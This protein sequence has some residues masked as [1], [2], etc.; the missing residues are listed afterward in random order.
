MVI[1]EILGVSREGDALVVAVVA[2][3]GGC[4]SPTELQIT[5]SPLN[6]ALFFPARS[7]HF[8]PQRAFPKTLLIKKCFRKINRLLIVASSLLSFAIMVP[9][10]YLC[11]EKEVLLFL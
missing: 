7:C 11:D 5:M 8:P 6:P 3:V 10:Q 2:T 4:T 9:Y 1:M